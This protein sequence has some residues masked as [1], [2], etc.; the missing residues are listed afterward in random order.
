MRL[1][2]LSNNRSSFSL[3]HAQVNLHAPII[4]VRNLPEILEDSGTHIFGIVNV[5]DLDEGRH[6]QIKSLEI[7][8]GDPDGHF[9][10]RATPRRG[11]YN[12]EVHS[13]LDR[14]KTPS[15]YNLTLRATDN[16][17][18]PRHTYKVI[19]VKLADKNDNAP[20]FNK[21]LYEVSVPESAPVNSPIIR[22]KV[23]DA[24]EGRN[25]KVFLE[26]VGGNEGGEFRINPETGML[27]T[28]CVLDAES[29]AMYTLTVSAIDQGNTG[30]RKQSS[31]RVKISVL[32]INDNDPVFE[33]SN[34]TIWID[35]NEPAG[36]TV[37]KVSARDKDSGDNSYISYSI[38]N[39]NKVP[40]D[41]DA[42]T[43]IIR[44]TKLI[45]YETM[46]RQYV[47]KI[48]ASDWGRPYRRQTEMQLYINVRDVNDNRPQFERVDCVGEVYKLAPIGAEVLTVNAID[49]DA[50]SEIVFRMVGG[51]EDGC[52]NLDPS[53]GVVS[54]GCDL[55]DVR[56]K[57]RELNITATDG[58]HYSDVMR[59]Q[60]SLT[61]NRF[62][63]SP[64]HPFAGAVN[65]LMSPA[66]DADSSPA[67]NAL[68]ECRE[69]GVIHRQSEMLAS[70]ERNNLPVQKSGGG[71]SAESG[72]G[73]GDGRDDF[74]MMPSRY[75]ENIHSPEFIDFPSNVRINETIA[76]G[77]TVA[78]IRARDRDLGYNGKLVYGISDGDH[79][80]VF[81][82]DPDTG[83]LKIIGY[84]D[85]EREDEYLLNVTVYDLGRPQKSASK[86]LPV[87]VVDEND[88]APKFGK[89]LF[90]FRIREDAEIGTVVARLNATDADSRQFAG[91][92]Y[93]LLTNTAHF[94]IDSL[95]GVLSVASKLDREQ[96]DVY[97]LIIRATD[98]GEI[99]GD[100]NAY[101]SFGTS[102][103]T[104][105]TLSGGGYIANNNNPASPYDTSVLHADALVRILIDDVN[106]NAPK[107]S[108]DQ[109]S[110]RVREDIPIG[111]VVI[112]VDAM[113]KDL[114]AGGEVVYRF[115]D[116][117]DFERDQFRIDRLS[118]TVRLARAL[119]FEERQSMTLCVVASDK[120]NPPLTAEA[121]ILI[122]V[123]DVNENQYTPQFEDFVLADQGNSVRENQPIGTYVMNINVRDNDPPGPDS[124]VAFSIR[125]GDGLG[126][127]TIDNEGMYRRPP[128]PPV[129]VGR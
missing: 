82:I 36:T 88:N 96:Q 1:I 30:T 87:T 86:V 120:G 77:K 37:T 20:V 15:G 12:I 25:A 24:D 79:D 113:D 70:A 102:H 78:W 110:V 8:D 106:D 94:Q 45:D 118:G 101:K 89:T 126:L 38:A 48:R 50:A 54:V 111:S 112:S 23:S 33:H 7:T 93:F 40:F 100:G 44:T 64:S 31:A 6:G 39:L 21:A 90:S 32:D 73:S 116:K 95:T 49:F 117:C 66:S 35:E 34:V 52:F 72:M 5:E 84:L 129:C 69:T 10:I 80:S 65:R 41:V 17:V 127:F 46:R 22:L 18:P 125:G 75:R 3:L 42:F 123:I 59:V 47:L 121:T 19:P 105:S 55:G 67:M 108:A 27:Y 74:L 104:G 124:R 71:S 2:K 122:E 11:E 63:G 56:R 14:E 58:T 9:R 68:F 4:Y 97:E 119:D 76:L 114:G 60:I 57:A 53:S 98:G 107:F 91:I 81:R 28:A 29:Q 103:R 61:D 62:A 26:I 109:Y 43:G 16:G 115:N 51:N 13:L 128:L 83:E 85:R 99:V 92:L